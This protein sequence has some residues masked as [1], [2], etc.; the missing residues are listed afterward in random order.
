MKLSKLR[1]KL[2]YATSRVKHV[3]KLLQKEKDH[4]TFLPPTHG[5]GALDQ[6]SQQRNKKI[7]EDRSQ[8]HD[9]R[10]LQEEF[11]HKF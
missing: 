6:F 9:G 5:S 11:L 1:D 10:G 3:E 2:Y 4:R 7:G 8:G